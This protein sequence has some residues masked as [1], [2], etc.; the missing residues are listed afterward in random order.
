[1]YEQVQ[2]IEDFI[3]LIDLKKRFSAKKFIFLVCPDEEENEEEV[4]L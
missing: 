3:W 4:D 2:L 1:M